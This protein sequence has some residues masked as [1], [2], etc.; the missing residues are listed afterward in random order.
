M[1][2]LNGCRYAKAGRQ[3]R[4]TYPVAPTNAA[5]HPMRIVDALER[6]PAGRRRSPP[7]HRSEP[8][9]FI[10]GRDRRRV[11]EECRRRG[12]SPPSPLALTAAGL[13]PTPRSLNGVREKCRRRADHRLILSSAAADFTRRRNRE[14]PRE[15]SRRARQI[16]HS[17]LAHRRRTSPHAEIVDPFERSAAGAADHRTAIAA[18]Q[19]VGDRPRARGAVEFVR[20]VWRRSAVDGAHGYFAAAID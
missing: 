9:A 7:Y 5:L 11:R 13:H 15:E 2:G 18:H 17:P 3:E 10:P 16:P 1:V 12:R 19:R 6:S 14:C 4:L 8:A 20:R